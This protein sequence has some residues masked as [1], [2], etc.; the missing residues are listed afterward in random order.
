GQLRADDQTDFRTRKMGDQLLG[1]GGRA[2]DEI[3]RRPRL[4]ERLEVSGAA[5][6][7]E[8]KAHPCV[9]RVWGAIGDPFARYTRS[10]RRLP[11]ATRRRTVARATSSRHCR[12]PSAGLG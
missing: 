6:F 7:E 9:L 2:A 8:A 1:E 4:R 3:E 12:R 10:P 11:R 5:V